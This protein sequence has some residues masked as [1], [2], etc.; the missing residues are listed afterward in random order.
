MNIIATVRTALLAV[1]PVTA[2]VGS[3]TSAR[4]WGD[5]QRS[6]TVPCI[7]I[8]VD[9]EDESPCLVGQEDLVTGS[10]V[11]TCRA[12]TGAA[13]HTLQ[14]AV[15]AGLDD[16]GLLI[17]LES[18]ARSATPKAEG[19]TEHWYDEVMDYTIQWTETV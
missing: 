5:W 18:T 2:I 13:A 6:E 15:R 19:S 11:I 9:A 17:S 7:I 1:S 10:V 4:I 12:D 8:E 14:E 3:G 16:S